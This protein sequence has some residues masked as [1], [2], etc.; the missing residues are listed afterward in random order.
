MA[1]VT[2][3]KVELFVGTADCSDVAGVCR[4]IE[5]GDEGVVLGERLVE[6]ICALSTDRV[7]VEVVIVRADG[8]ELL[9]WRVASSLAPLLRLL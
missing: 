9:T 2:N 7:H 8:K 4:P 1:L 6:S 3:I 5:S